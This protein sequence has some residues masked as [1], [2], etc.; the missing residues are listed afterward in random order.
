MDDA[1]YMRLAEEFTARLHREEY[2]HLAGLKDTF[3]T[4]SLFEEFHELFTRDAVLQRL[5]HRDDRV[6]RHL[7]EFAVHRYIGRRLSGLTE[8]IANRQNA[9]RVRVGGEALPFRQA[10]GMLTRVSDL[11]TR[12]RIERRVA[13]AIDPQNADRA[14]RIAGQREIA[15]ELE[16]PPVKV[17]CSVLAEDA[18]KAAIEDLQKHREDRGQETPQERAAAKIPTKPS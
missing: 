17:H 6:G 2:S 11:E 9:A 16:L 1:L 8:R 3:D 10:W 14:Q 4:E 13:A 18:I 12:R 5:E 15:R 7:A